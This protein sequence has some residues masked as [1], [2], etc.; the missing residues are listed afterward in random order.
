[1]C[2]NETFVLMS[3]GG[4]S[5]P[6]WSPCIVAQVVGFILSNCEKHGV[7]GVTILMFCPQQPDALRHFFPIMSRQNWTPI[8]LR[9]LIGPEKTNILMQYEQILSMDPGEKS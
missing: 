3:T 9:Q 7:T 6:E 4:F 2:L 5:Q 8:R 1:M